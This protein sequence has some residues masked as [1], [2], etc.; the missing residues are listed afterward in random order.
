MFVQ[1]SEFNLRDV[2]LSQEIMKDLVLQLKPTKSGRI[3]RK[4][5]ILETGF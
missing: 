4:N 2:S 1:R 3:I 5:G